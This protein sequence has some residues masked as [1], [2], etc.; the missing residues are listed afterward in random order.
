MSS[1]KITI[2]DKVVGYLVWDAPN[3]TAI[4][5]SDEEYVNSSINLSPL[6]HEN[7]LQLL[8]GFD[9]HK[10]FNGLPSCFND[11]LPDSFGN[12][13]FKEWLEQNK[14]DQSNLNPVERLLYVGNRG[15]GALE[16]QKGYDIPNIIHSIDLNELAGISDDIIKRKYNQKDYL[17]NP[18]ALKNILVIG[19]SFGGAQAKILVA[20]ND[21]NELLAGDIIHKNEVEYFII[22]LE[23]DQSNIWHKEKNF[24]EFEFNQIARESGLIV[25]DSKLIS[26]DQSTH[27]ASKRFDRLKN[28]KVHTQTVNAL[29]GFYGRNTEFSYEEIF[30]IIAYLDL[31]YVNFEQ[32]FTQMVFNVAVSNRD[33]HTKNFSF[34][35]NKSGQWSLTPAYDL[36]YPFDPYQNFNTPHQ[37]SINGKNLGIDRKDLESVAKRVGIR[38]YNQI[39]NRVIDSVATFGNKI[40]QYG[41]NKNTTQL[42]VND[43]ESNR[44]RISK[45]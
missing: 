8:N 39:I 16:Y 12:I 19:S 13:V 15:V 41:L 28:E 3:Q 30:R 44:K 10:K 43:L 24:V 29:T 17:H 18:E 38:N 22:K 25:A 42:I 14:I 26:I 23:H 37:I 27:F 2:W 21:K 5:E 20:I 32:L 36:T 40:Q 31:P 34:M 7:K 35:M 9:F 33:D 6:L 45:S 4:F 11:S 1:A